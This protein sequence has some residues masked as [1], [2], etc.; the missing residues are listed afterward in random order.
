MNHRVQFRVIIV[1]IRK[2]PGLQRQEKSFGT[3]CINNFSTPINMKLQG[4][5]IP[6]SINK[7]SPQFSAD[8]ATFTEEILNEKIR[9]LCSVYAIRKSKN[10]PCFKMFDRHAD[11]IHSE[12]LDG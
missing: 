9:F 5:C 8:L 3:P 1:I 7:H 12:K 10:P 2:V 11:T 6:L 4:T